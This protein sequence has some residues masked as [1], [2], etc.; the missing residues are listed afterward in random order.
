VR[1]P[2][3]TGSVP[4]LAVRLNDGQRIPVASRKH[5]GST[6]AAAGRCGKRRR[7]ASMQ[8]YSLAITSLNST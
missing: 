5:H 8:P 4:R 1:R 3:S 6:I 2:I 7:A